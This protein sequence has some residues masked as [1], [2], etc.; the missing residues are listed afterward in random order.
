MTV[1]R[2]FAVPDGLA[3]AGQLGR[4]RGGPACATAPRWSIERRFGKGRVMAFLT[5]AAP[6]WNNWAGN[7]SFVVIMLD[8]AGLS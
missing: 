3:S 7:P 6:T 1:Q 4:S 5:T 8:L 2:Y